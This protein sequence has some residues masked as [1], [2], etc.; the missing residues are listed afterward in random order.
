VHEAGLAEH[1]VWGNAA[2]FVYRVTTCR[3]GRWHIVAASRLQLVTVASCWASS[4]SGRLSIRTVCPCSRLSAVHLSHQP[5]SPLATLPRRLTYKMS[6]HGTTVNYS[7][8][9]LRLRSYCKLLVSVP[10]WQT[11]R[12]RSLCSPVPASWNHSALYT[13]LTYA[14]LLL[15]PAHRAEALSDDA[16]LTSVCL[17]RTS[18]LSREP[19]C[20]G[21]LT[22]A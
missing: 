21:R 15:C 22:L 11:V 16:R 17:S 19:R 13:L 6:L 10:R 20:V 12:L 14:S 18:G 1:H 5:H 8:T 7:Y 2:R 4:A 3:P 9:R